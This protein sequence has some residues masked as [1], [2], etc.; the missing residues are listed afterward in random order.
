MREQ[1]EAP[2]QAPL[3][4]EEEE[5]GMDPMPAAAAGVAGIAASSSAAAGGDRF[6]GAAAVPRVP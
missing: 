1:A 2:A 5:A 4:L 3:A 6:G